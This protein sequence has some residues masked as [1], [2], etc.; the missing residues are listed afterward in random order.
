MML[1]ILIAVLTAVAALSVLIPL[2]RSRQS[3]EDRTTSADEAVYREQLD[4]IEVELER[5]LIDAD[6]AEAARTETARRLLTAHQRTQEKTQAGPGITRR[7][8]AQGLAIL[9]LPMIA[10]GFYLGIGSP[11]L[12]DQPLAARLNVPAEDQSVDVL[13]A[14]VEQHLAA[15]PEDGQGWAI[16]APVYMTRGLPQESARAYANALRLLGP[17]QEWFTDMGEA[18]A[19]ANHGNVDAKARQ[20][21]EQAVK[22]DSEAVKPRFFLALALGQEGK[23]SDAIKAWETLLDGADETAN[24]VQAARQELANLTGMEPALAGPSASDM[25]AAEDMADDDR[26]SM[27]QTMVEGLAA[28]LEVNGG[29]SAEWNQLIRAYMVL[30]EKDN[31]IKALKSAEDAF[32]EKPDDLARI[33][34][35]AGQLGLT[36]S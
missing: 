8:A 16:I 36:G 32:A 12:T 30:G 29:T 1:W 15:N 9:V 23:T 24:W 5:G 19:M 11:D 35:A 13:V 2:A 4:A 10:L 26:Q 20:A 18:L 6:A 21:F 34:D 7:R 31:A 22:L 17:K 25:A 27:I 33:K 28:R 14:R 3:S